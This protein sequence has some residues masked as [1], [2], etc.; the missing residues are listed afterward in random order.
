[1]DNQHMHREAG[2]FWNW[3]VSGRKKDLLRMRL[4]AKTS[5]DSCFYQLNQEKR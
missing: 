1:M 2:F 4:P 5:A 3:C